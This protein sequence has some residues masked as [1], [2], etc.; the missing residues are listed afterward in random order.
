M[1]SPGRPSVWRR[2]HLLGFWEGIAR[3]LSSERAAEQ[4]GVSPAVG[5]RW[6]RE[7]GGMSPVRSTPQTGRYLSYEEREEI[8]LLR[9]EGHGVREIARR[10]HRSPSTISR[11]IRRNAATRGGGF[12]YRA[13]T[14]Q[15]HAGRRAAR[16]KVS[17][18]AANDRLR[19]YVQERLAGTVSSATSMGPPSR[20]ELGTTQ[21]RARPRPLEPS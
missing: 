21:G 9:A 5:G 2:E 17:K 1:R 11:E 15:W 20:H 4:V 13:T 18:L 8:A 3:G 12:D 10:L 7:A 14:A 6:F 16:P 19:A